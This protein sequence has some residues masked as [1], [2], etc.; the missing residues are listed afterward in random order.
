ME[1]TQP[2]VPKESWNTLGKAI[3]LTGGAAH[4][5]LA[6]GIANTLHT[7]VWY[8]EGPIQISVPSIRGQM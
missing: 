3:Y 2:A 8:C 1:Y 5:M 4:I 7:D 6:I